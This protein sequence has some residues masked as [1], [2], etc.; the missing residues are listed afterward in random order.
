MTFNINFTDKDHINPLQLVQYMTEHSEFLL[1]SEELY[2]ADL[3]IISTESLFRHA[4]HNPLIHNIFINGIRAGLHG[5]YLAGSIA[6]CAAI[7]AS[8]KFE[9]CKTDYRD[10]IRD[11]FERMERM[12][13]LSCKLLKDAQKYALPVAALALQNETFE[14][15]IPHNPKIVEIRNNINHGNF[16]SFCKS[17]D[18]GDIFFT[19]ECLQADYFEL[20]TA[21]VLWVQAVDQMEMEQIKIQT[22]DLYS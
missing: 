14:T 12:P 7:E 11:N 15:V 3:Y 9:L 20:V 22:G 4:I 2:V 21:S 16:S 13:V 18:T 8:L 17:T 1:G 10:D 19:P 6:L 5:L